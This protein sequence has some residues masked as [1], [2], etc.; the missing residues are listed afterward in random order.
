M[1]PIDFNS[2]TDEELNDFLATLTPSEQA[3]FV[4]QMQ[5]GN[6]NAPAWSFGV[7]APQISPA[8]FGLS[9][10]F[11]PNPDVDA[12]GRVEPWDL[13]NQQQGMNLVQDRMQTANSLNGAALGGMGSFDPALFQPQLIYSGPTIDDAT[14]GRDFVTNLASAGGGGWSSMLAAELATTGNPAA[15][16]AKVMKAI[17]EAVTNP[18]LANDPDAQAILAGLPRR[19]PQYDEVT[20]KPLPTPEG[21]G[22]YDLDTIQKYAFD[23]AEKLA[24][25]PSSIQGGYIDPATGT[26][27]ANAPTQ[28]YND[29]AQ[30][31]IDA[32]YSFP[33]ERY[34]DPARLEAIAPV[35]RAGFE[36]STKR[37]AASKEA[38]NKQATLQAKSYEDLQK[39]YDAW[40]KEKAAFKPIE[41][42]VSAGDAIAGA[43]GKPLGTR[44][45]STSG[46]ELYG[47]DLLPGW[48]EAA[49]SLTGFGQEPFKASE[50]V[51]TAT[52]APAG[53][54]SPEQ[55]KY[56]LG[57][58]PPTATMQNGAWTFGTPER[59]S[60][61]NFLAK[62][63]DE[64]YAPIQT[65]QVDQGMLD[66][67]RKKKD[68][69]A[70]QATLLAHRINP[71]QAKGI[72]ARIGADFQA[73]SM[74]QQGR[75]PFVDQ[76]MQ[77]M[78]GQRGLGL[79]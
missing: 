49:S 70:Y 15:A 67:V 37:I 47:K 38:A 3:E 12:K 22:A 54:L 41:S 69:A 2:M 27:Y 52:N 66:E 77:R 25:D 46:P 73:M 58:L 9:G 43:V 74:A 60:A 57:P 20:G 17:D 36:E 53:Y 79:G 16:Y 31:F 62:T 45:V 39:E 40:Q 78:L 8:N 55:Q 34:D 14:P 61:P 71:Y 75:T 19:A 21:V 65:R 5:Y 35:D 28:K 18:D 30:S 56:N 42:S 76:Y 48:V 51:S 1:P 63:A 10:M 29:F 6:A 7:D 11:A 68:A 33:T 23:W 32:G 13:S 64:N 26:R 24:S 72:P 4:A 59:V 50:P 44:R